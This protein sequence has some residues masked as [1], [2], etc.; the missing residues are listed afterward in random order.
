MTRVIF[1]GPPGAGKGTQAKIIQETFNIIQL[2]TGDMLR[3]AVA[4]NT[5][6]GQQ[7]KTIMEEGGLVPDDLI[8]AMISE[9]IDQDDCKN[10]FILDGFP[11][12]V[13]QAEALD[14]MLE[15]RGIAIDAVIELQVD[16]EAL[17]ERISN[18]YTCKQCGQGYNK[19]FQQP[20]V[21]NICD[22]CGSSEFVFRADDNAETVASRLKAYHEQTAPLLPY[23]R[24][25]GMLRS[26]NAMAEIDKVTEE[27]GKSIREEEA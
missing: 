19:L 8:I 23:Y 16:D 24:G 12:T 20:K 4:A 2:S 3:A 11:R 5:E 17:V 10:G 1:L 26:V 27:I 15:Q 9:R 21:E 6:L 14:T 22:K 25:K 13:G 7:A 18:R